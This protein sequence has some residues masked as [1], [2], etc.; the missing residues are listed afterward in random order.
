MCSSLSNRIIGF[1]H[2]GLINQA[3]NN[4]DHPDTIERYAVVDLVNKHYMVYSEYEIRN[5]LVARSWLEYTFISPMIVFQHFMLDDEVFDE[6]RNLVSNAGCGYITDSYY[7]LGPKTEL[8]GVQGKYAQAFRVPGSWVSW[9]ESFGLDKL[10]QARLF[11]T[12]YDE[13]KLTPSKLVSLSPLVES[14]G[15]TSARIYS[16]KVNTSLS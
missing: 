8:Y 13:A 5:G 14:Y 15:C 6:F 9:A 11:A 1:S 7:T 10:Q 4:M 3:V 12:G 16:L 2:L